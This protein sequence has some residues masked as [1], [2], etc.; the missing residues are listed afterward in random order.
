MQ[1]SM[2]EKNALGTQIDGFEIPR[3]W[4]IKQMEPQKL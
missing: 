3:S 2:T 1:V 4:N